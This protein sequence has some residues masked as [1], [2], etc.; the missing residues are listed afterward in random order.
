[1]IQFDSSYL[2]DLRQELAGERLGPAFELIESQDPGELLAVS[3]HV[4][5]E[6]RVGAERSREPM[7][8][9][10]ALDTFLEGFLIL[11]PDHRF[12]AA[13]ARLWMAT[14][15]PRR[16]VHAIDLLI[17]TA[18]VVENAPLVT[19]NVKDFSRVP[20]LRVLGY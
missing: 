10:R 2:I 18:A 7:A 6:L 4:V 13:Y 20:G 12:A 3:V 1:M 16:S 19:K 11:Y 9:H 8:E 15:R 17:A 14:N 5:S